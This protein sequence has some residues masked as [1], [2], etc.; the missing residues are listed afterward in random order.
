L[1]DL[2]H[3]L[4]GVAA[5]L[6]LRV[7]AL[8]IRRESM[9]YLCSYMLQPKTFTINDLSEVAAAEESSHINTLRRL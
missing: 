2:A 6:H 9:G 7:N 5:L 3:S 1:R 4:P 8:A